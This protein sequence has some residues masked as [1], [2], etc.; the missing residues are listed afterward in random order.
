MQ[1][2]CKLA[3]LTLLLDVLLLLNRVPS[4]RVGVLARLVKAIFATLNPY[5]CNKVR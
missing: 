4:R 2:S 3:S 5:Q 1:L